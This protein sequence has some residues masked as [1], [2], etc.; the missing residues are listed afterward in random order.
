MI[1]AGRMIVPNY[2][3]EYCI[4]GKGDDPAGIALKQDSLLWLPPPFRWPCAKVKIL[5]GI[6]VKINN[7]FGDLWHL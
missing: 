4:I 6:Y 7:F 3:R 5:P 2:Y 1:L